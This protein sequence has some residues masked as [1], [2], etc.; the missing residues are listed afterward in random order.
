MKMIIITFNIMLY[1]LW[2]VLRYEYWHI[3]H[4]L[5]HKERNKSYCTSCNLV[6]QGIER[7]NFNAGSFK[8]ALYF[9]LLRCKLELRN[10]I[11]RTIK[12][13]VTKE[14]NKIINSS[15]IQYIYW[16]IR[17]KAIKLRLI[18]GRSGRTNING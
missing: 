2:V 17:I 5:F 7:L 11:R 16:K 18:N 14:Y 8:F 12:P 4:V 15:I 13:F 9:Q 10:Y 1:Q 6:S 3:A